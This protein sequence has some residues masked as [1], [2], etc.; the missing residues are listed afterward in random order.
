MNIT[1]ITVGKIKEKYLRDAIDEYSKRL[2]RY[3]KLDI[4]EL[5]DEKTPDNASEKEEEAIKEKEG[6][7][8]LS[9]IKDNMFVIAMDLGGKQLTSE[10][11]SSYIDNLGVTGNSNLAFI[12][13]GS[14]GISKSVL[15]RAN[16]K[17]CF[18]KMT[19]PH[20]LFR[21]M[22]LEQIYRGF[23]IMKGEPYHK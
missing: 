21:V 9:K 4:V 7:G 3:C 22:L 20:Q 1:I 18:S 23:R 8:I 6:Q 14:L 17:L 11:F 10:E 13:G 15:A 16:Y 19:F 2:G 12:I 5:A